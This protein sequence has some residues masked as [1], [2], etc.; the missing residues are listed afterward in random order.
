MKELDRERVGT[1]TR[2][3]F[4]ILSSSNVR[5]LNNNQEMNKTQDTGAGAGKGGV[6]EEDGYE[7][8]SATL[9][10]VGW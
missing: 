9:A 5:F 2:A 1:D 8:S 6:L 7:V 4:F 3:C 10:E